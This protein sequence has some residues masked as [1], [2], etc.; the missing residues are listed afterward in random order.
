[1]ELMLF[2]LNAIADVS[3]SSAVV[4]ATLVRLLA[5]VLLWRSRFFSCDSLVSRACSLVGDV[6]NGTLGGMIVYLCE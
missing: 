6:L 4:L 2:E 5:V 1:M 3:C